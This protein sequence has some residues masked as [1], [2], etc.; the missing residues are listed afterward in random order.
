ME[1]NNQLPHHPGFPSRIPVPALTQRKQ[2][3]FLKVEISS[4][5]G[6]DKGRSQNTHRKLWKYC[7]I[8]WPKEMSNQSD[9]PVAPF[10]RYV[11]LVP[12]AQNP[13]QAFHTAGKHPVG[14]PP[15]GKV[16]TVVVHYIHGKPGFTTPP[17]VKKKALS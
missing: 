8:S 3:K 12:W 5:T 15:F 10:R 16:G 7:F 11:V 9:C 2:H 17:S 14:P 4:R 13:S 6:R 1:V